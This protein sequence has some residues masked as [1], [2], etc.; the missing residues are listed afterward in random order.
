MTNK[1]NKFLTFCC[2]LLPGAGEM[3]LGFMKQGISLMS[4]FFLVWAVSGLLNL[5]ALLFIAP[6]IWFYSFFHTHNL[7]S[8]PDEEFYSLEDDY[9]IHL[10][11]FP[12]LTK[13]WLEKNRKI[14]AAALI[15][16]GA[17]LLW[18]YIIDFLYVTIDVFSLSSRVYMLLHAFGDFSVR[19]VFA[20]C[21]I[22]L[23]IHLIR[24]KSKELY[25]EEK[26]KDE[27]F[28]LL[29]QKEDQDL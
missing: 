9:L 14:A 2:S 10:K 26:Q 20:V 6:V 3:Y 11:A 19:A 24:S 1:R 17:L 5:P 23:G 7:N 15:V 4:V 27:S 25:T 28:P 16:L 12:F 21:I 13:G 8:L 18:N 29:T 22:V